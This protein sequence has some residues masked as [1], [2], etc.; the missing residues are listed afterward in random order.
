MDAFFILGGRGMVM[1]I[2]KFILICFVAYL[3]IAIFSASR[4]LKKRQAEMMA[5]Y[6]EK[7]EKYAHIDEELFDN[8]PDPELKEG[9]LTHIFHKEDED[10]EHLKDNLTEGEKVIYTLYQMQIAVDEGRGSVYN[11]FNSPS[12]E[13]L[14]FLVDSFK[15]VG[16]ET[17][18]DL[19]EKVVALVIAEQTGKYNEE[20]IDEDAPTFQDYTFDY[21]DMV[22]SEQL[23]AKL[24]SYM[25]A[26]KQDFIN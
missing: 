20:N 17:L 18:A 4:V 7:Q 26:H 3:A 6:E 8:T 23:D 12:K 14:P 22:E 13:Y 25:R 10:F 1:T 2:L 21:L 11:F 19:M 5:A 24:V 9:V 16:S 15:A